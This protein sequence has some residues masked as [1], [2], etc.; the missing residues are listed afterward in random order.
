MASSGLYV[1]MTEAQT[2][3]QAGE[4]QSCLDY[5]CPRCAI[6]LSFDERYLV[7]RHPHT[8]GCS[9]TLG[10]QRAG[11]Y[12]VY[13]LLR[14]RPCRFQLIKA[15]IACSELILLQITIGSDDAELIYADDGTPALLLDTFEKIVVMMRP[16]SPH[17]CALA[18]QLAALWVELDARNVISGGPALLLDTNLPPSYFVCYRCK[19]RTKIKNPYRHIVLP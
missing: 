15:C 16:V 5:Y 2:L 19:R 14:A 7:F 4:A 11:I 1:A 10:Y 13:E 3:V 8:T 9:E 6:R 17:L 12:Y 18:Q